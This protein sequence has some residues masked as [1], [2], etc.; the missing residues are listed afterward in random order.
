MNICLHACNNNKRAGTTT[1]IALSI[2]KLYFIS[3]STEVFLVLN[4]KTQNLVQKILKKIWI[5]RKVHTVHGWESHAL[6]VSVFQELLCNL[7]A[8]PSQSH[9]TLLWAFPSPAMGNSTQLKQPGLGSGSQ[10][11]RG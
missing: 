8:V 6:N 2:L 10:H 11:G 5:N 3:K 7:V 9:S 1:S 4:R